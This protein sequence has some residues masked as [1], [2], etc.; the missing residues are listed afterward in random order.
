[1]A[2]L[3]AVYLRNR[4]LGADRL[5]C[6]AYE[7]PACMDLELAQGCSGV[8]VCGGGCAG[9]RLAMRAWLASCAMP[10]HE[11]TL[12]H[13]AHP[14]LPHSRCPSLLCQMW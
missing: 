9:S 7:T 2:S 14:A 5:R 8:C 13:P 4:G 10:H 3:L 12:P 11:P 6:W 1:M